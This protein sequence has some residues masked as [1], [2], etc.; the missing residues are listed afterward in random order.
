MG[1]FSK[2]NI[3]KKKEVPVE[4]EATWTVSEKALSLVI[5]VLTP[6]I[7]GLYSD[8]TEI[9]MKAVMKITAGLLRKNI[10]VII[11]TTSL[12]YTLHPKEVH[13]VFLTRVGDRISEGEDIVYHR[14]DVVQNSPTDP[15]MLEVLRINPQD[16]LR[17]YMIVD[18]EEINISSLI[19]DCSTFGIVS[20]VYKEIRDKQSDVP[21][22]IDN[23]IQLSTH[24]NRK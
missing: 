17:I 19:A 13:R 10:H 5:G 23:V 21:D 3:F 11:D 9:T 18:G 2:L 4:E 16:F 24:R 12:S 14:M 22:T 8:S 7:M 15:N 20:E 1:F 6:E